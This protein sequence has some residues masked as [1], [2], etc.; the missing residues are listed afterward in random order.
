MIRRPPRSTLF[1]YTTLFRSGVPHRPGDGLGE[2][3]VAIVDVEEVVLLEV[4]GNVQVGTAIE[5]H[6]A[7]DHAQ[8][9]SL[10]ASV[11]AG[12]IAHIHEMAAVIAEQAVARPGMARLALRVR[13]RAALGG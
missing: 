3:A 1:P 9:V 6:V 2:R 11:D 12:L 10:D 8:A 13:P 5:V 4:V 7:R